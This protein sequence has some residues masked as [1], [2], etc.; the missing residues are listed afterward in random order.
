MT[1][2]GCL[3]NLPSLS[4]ENTRSFTRSLVRNTKDN[5]REEKGRID[6]DDSG[7]YILLQYIEIHS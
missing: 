2:V 7:T 3:P 5:K 4:L 6:W 1:V